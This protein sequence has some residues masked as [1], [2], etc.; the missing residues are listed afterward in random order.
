MGSTLTNGVVEQ[1]GAAICTR[2]VGQARAATLLG[3]KVRLFEAGAS[4]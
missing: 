3:L 1:L 4:T 2:D